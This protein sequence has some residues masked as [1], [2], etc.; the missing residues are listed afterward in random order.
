ML[1]VL[2]EFYGVALAELIQACLQ[3]LFLNIFVLFIFVLSWKILPGERSSEEIDN[4]MPD[5][6]QIISS[7]LF[8]SEMGCQRC[9]SGRSCQIFTLYEWNV[10]AFRIFVAFCK[11]KINDI[12]VVASC[13]GSNQKVIRLDVSMNNP[14]L[15]NLL[16][17]FD[18]LLSNE[19]TSFEVKFPFALH[20]QVFET[21]AEHI[22]NHDMELI[23][24]ISFVG[25]DIV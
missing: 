8:F 1:H 22:H 17:S 5:G 23:F 4:H 2:L 15:V 3:L 12:D 14:F 16:N 24:L 18:H 9:V 7:R 19:T 21:W 10:L 20:E 6:F 13:I 11:T 25:A